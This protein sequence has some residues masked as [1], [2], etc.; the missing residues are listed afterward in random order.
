MNGLT[1]QQL[2][3]LRG[4]LI[5]DR[6]EIA[7]RLA[8][9]KSF[10]MNEPMGSELGELSLYDNH[11]GDVGSEM[12]E[13]GKDLALAELW[14]HQLQK[15]EEAID[16]MDAGTYGR[17]LR[18]GEPIPFERL[19][20]LPSAEYCVRHVQDDEVSRQRPIEEQ[21]LRPAMRS[22]TDDADTTAFDGEDAWQI[23]ERWGT[24]N[25]PALQEGRDLDDYND[26]EIESGEPDGFVEPIESFLA[27]DIYGGNVTFVRNDAYREYTERGEGELY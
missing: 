23:V 8:G 24:S 22:D 11:P 17:C 18:C 7:K 4:Q 1:Q 16:R 20:A 12:F 6:D 3:Q 10:G 21:F 9:S 5:A 15:T 19:S 27:T 26:M 13:R 25:T 2:E 14:E